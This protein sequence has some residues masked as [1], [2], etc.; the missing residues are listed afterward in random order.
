MMR[1]VL[2]LAAAVGC[3]A[4]GAVGGAG[5]TPASPFLGTW[6][7]VD[8][9]D[10]S[11]EQLTFGADGTMFF[12]DDSAH[13][14]NG[15]AALALDTGVVTGNTWTGSGT[16]SLRCPAVGTTLSG[17]FFQFTLNP[18]GTLSGSAGPELW[19]RARP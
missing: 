5:A 3:I 12:R 16:A 13:A 8:T 7:A 19:T 10:G 14:C 4:L 2:L 15:V 9:S 6:W 18:D 11:L 1:R 17:L